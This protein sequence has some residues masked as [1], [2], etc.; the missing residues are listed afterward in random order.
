MHSSSWIRRQDS[1]VYAGHDCALCKAQMSNLLLRCL[2]FYSS[3]LLSA[4]VRYRY[5]LL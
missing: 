5:H 1:L 3:E 2:I 4:S